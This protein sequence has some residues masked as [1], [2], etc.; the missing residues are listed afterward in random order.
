MLN[1]YYELMKLF[2]YTDEIPELLA[3]GGLY[4]DKL[5]HDL[6]FVLHV[7]NLFIENIGNLKENKTFILC[8]IYKAYSFSYKKALDFFYSY[9]MILFAIKSIL[10]DS[11]SYG[12]YI[13]QNEK[14]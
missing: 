3:L 12:K 7:L 13:L 9:N 14:L 2:K 11:F 4:T 1:F 10:T 5:F 8:M 6:S